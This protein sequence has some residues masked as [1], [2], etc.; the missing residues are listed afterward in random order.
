MKEIQN[1]K[2][3][4]KEQSATSSPARQGAGGLFGQRP[5]LSSASSE[6]TEA[7][8]GWGTGALGRCQCEGVTGPSIFLLH[9][10]AL[11]GASR[12]YCPSSRS[13]RGY[14]ESEAQ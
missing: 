7:V 8:P 1:C 10:R 5:V 12:L 9:L 13:P 11:A 6:L 14:E 3:S 2:S 4:W